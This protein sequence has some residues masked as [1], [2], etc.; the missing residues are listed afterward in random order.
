MKIEKDNLKLTMHDYGDVMGWKMNLIL[1]MGALLPF[2]ILSLILSALALKNVT[3][4]VLIAVP[5]AISLIINFYA[6]K[7]MGGK[8]QFNPRPIK[9]ESVDQKNTG[10][11]MITIISLV[12]PFIAMFVTLSSIPRIDILGIFLLVTIMLIIF[13]T[14]Y[15]KENA[16]SQVLSLR[17]LFRRFYIAKTESRSTIY[18]FSNEKLQAD[19]KIKAYHVLDDVYIFGY[20]T[21]K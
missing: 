19:R 13:Y 8:K 16:V 5:F 15:E 1:S 3:F 9:I 18:L 12:I 6:I 21:N 2:F 10:E 20:P 4:S 14:F 7:F 11:N 17:L